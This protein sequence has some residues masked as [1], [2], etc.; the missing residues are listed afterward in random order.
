MANVYGIL[1]AI[2]QTRG[3]LDRA[4][5]MLKKAL[6]IDEKLG[7][8]EGMARAYGNIG[9][10]YQTRGELDRAE[11]MYKKSLALFKEIGAAPSVKQVQTWLDTL[12]TFR[13]KRSGAR[14]VDQSTADPGVRRGPLRRL[15]L[16]LCA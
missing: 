12:D 4:E 13:A 8:Q 11:E 15:R 5:E 9:L 16:N 2:Y 6:E 7:R 1:A 3:E 10:I 14:P